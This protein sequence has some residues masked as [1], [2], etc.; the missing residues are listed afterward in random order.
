MKKYALM[1]VSDKT[2]IVEFARS[3]TE[4]HYE[5]LASGGTAKHLEEAGI[6]VTLSLIHI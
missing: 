3:L 4:L 6:K 1:S 2:G 5:I